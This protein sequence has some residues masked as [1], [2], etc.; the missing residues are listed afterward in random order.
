M[1]NLKLPAMDYHN[2][3]QLANAGNGE[4]WTK[5]AY[6]TWIRRDGAEIHVKHHNSVI[7]RVSLTKT[8]IDNHG[9]HTTTTAN[10]LDR[11]VYANTGMHVCIRNFQ[12][13]L[14]YDGTN[15]IRPIDGEKTIYNKEM[16]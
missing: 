1:S 3:R 14:R 9:Y 8:V 2:L 6:Q 10:R 11:I 5:I 13:V 7:A 15:T 12:M 4:A 16:V